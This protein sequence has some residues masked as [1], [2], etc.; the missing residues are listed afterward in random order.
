MALGVLLHTA[1]I[2]SPGS[3]WLV[4][5]PQSHPFFGWLSS[6]IHVFRMPAF[7]WI[8]GY[9]CAMTFVR[10]GSRALV[11]T[12]MPRLLIPL[13]STALLLNVAQDLLTGWSRGESIQQVLARGLH[14]HHLWFLVDL[15]VFTALAIA[16]MPLLRRAA[17]RWSGRPA[18]PWQL[19]LLL[20]ALA[21]Y[22]IE[23]AARLTGVAYVRLLGLTSLY[24]LAR[25]FPY[26]AGGL[27]MYLLPAVRDRFA[28]T[29]AWLF[30]P[31]VLGVI[32]L[33]QLSDAPSRWLV[34][35]IH[36]GIL[37]ASWLGVG[38]LLGLFGRW[39]PTRSAFTQLVSESAYTVYLFHHVLVV[40]FG[41][42]L[43]SVAIGP[44]SKFLLV[45]AAA[46]GLSLALHLVLVR[47]VRVVRYLFNGK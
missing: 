38:A 27:F 10:Q 34:E 35:S 36:V 1:N 44:W 13:L 43:V 19:L 28:A 39:F 23:A 25:Y 11:Q 37:L 21:D 32:G 5:D 16:L 29:P 42:A 40:A 22:A 20:C 17:K 26:F 30:V 2:Y 14:L 18:P 3:S 41:L 31:A 46:G 12:R 47:R 15:L 45:C 8:S 24:E 33:Q 6:F 9:F 4:S 7:F